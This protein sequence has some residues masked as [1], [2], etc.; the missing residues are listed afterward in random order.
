[1]TSSAGPRSN[2][3][4]VRSA[5]AGWSFCK[6]SR[7]RLNNFNCASLPARMSWLPVAS[8]ITSN[9]ATVS[10]GWFFTWSS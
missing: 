7:M 9:S 5:G 1:M 3:F 8:S 4:V 10:S 2:I 6:S